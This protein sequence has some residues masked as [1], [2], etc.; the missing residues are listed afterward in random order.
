MHKKIFSITNILMCE[1]KIII[2][3]ILYIYIYVFSNNK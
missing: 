3:K 1:K 2:I